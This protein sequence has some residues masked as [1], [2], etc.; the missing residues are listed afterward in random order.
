MSFIQLQPTDIVVSSDAVTAPAWST[1]APT[2][3]RVV[4]ASSV[5]P[6]FYL[7]VYNSAS[8]A[9]VASTSPEFSIAYGH[10]LGS[11]SAAYNALVTG[12]TPTRTVYGQYRTLIYGDENSNLNFGSGNATSRDLYILNIERSKYKESLFPGTFNLKLVSG[13]TTLHLTDNSNDVSTVTYLDCGRAFTIVS[14]SNGNAT[15]LS[16][17][18]APTA[19]N[20]QTPS[21][22]Y[23]LFLPDIG[24]IVLNPR[25]LVLPPASGG[26][27]LAVTESNNS[28]AP[29]NLVLYN[30][31][32]GST[33]NTTAFSLNSQE[34]V[35]S[36]YVFVRVPNQ[37]FNYTTNPSIISGSGALLYSSMINF[38]QTYITTVGLYNTAGDLLAVAKLSKPLV[39][40]FTKEALIQVKLNW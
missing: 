8:A 13:S 31:I 11:G 15:L 14:G 17:P 18:A 6:S 39:K 5:A 4:S 19:T 2:L 30:A 25:A 21:G 38:P 7:N 36:D 12:S 29:N 16:P 37:A 10:L 27:S 9:T 33:A 28:L 22:S 24:T 26:I 1:G 32:S 23:G 35:S 3:A 20:G 40:D 34:T